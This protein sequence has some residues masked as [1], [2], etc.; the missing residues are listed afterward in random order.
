MSKRDL[1]L[2]LFKWKYSLIGY[3]VFV[4]ALVTVLVYLLPQ[5][6][7]SMSSVLVE[8][9]RAPVMRSD[10][11]LGTDEL[12][13]LNSAVAIILSRTVLSAAVD[14]VGLGE[15]DEPPS[16]IELIIDAIRSWLLEVGLS[17]P[18]SPR[19]AVIEKLQ[20]KLD[21]EPLASSNV[22]AISFSGKNPKWVTGIVNAVTDSYI[23]H[24]LKIF[25]SKGTSEVYRLQV[26]RLKQDLDERRKKLA[27]YKRRSSVSALSET[28]LAL[29]QLQSNLT[30]EL[31]N[32][33]DDLAELKTQF[34]RGHVKLTLAEDK[35]ENIEESLDDTRSKL[36]S[37]EMK[38]GTI[39]ELELGISSIEKSYEEYQKR[40]EEERLSDLA[41]PDVVNVRV[42][43][44]ATVPVQPGHSRLF[45]VVLGAFGG[46]ILTFAIA[47][48]REYFD[49]RVS[50]PTTVADLLGIPTLGSVER[51]GIIF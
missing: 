45:Y 46:L 24:H 21:V 27:D 15:S 38:E 20:D 50:D 25:S 29:V 9:N 4:V 37:I 16:T 6:Y 12:I 8:S 1:I 7:T 36:R 43:E 19:D 51:A 47:L 35:V 10:A 26:D 34:S 13:V 23:E 30:A 5:K 17:N 44:Y 14:K 11:A 2:F 39:E 3:F 42:I 41:N 48:I 40:Y 28:R 31:A 33:R 18:Q 49:H 32:A 22:I